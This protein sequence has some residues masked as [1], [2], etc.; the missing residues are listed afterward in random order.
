MKNETLLDE[1]ITKELE[2]LGKMSMDSEG[3]TKGVEG[4]AKLLDKRIELERIKIESEDRQKEID[5]KQAQMEEDRKDRLIK[6]IIAA[7]SVGAPIGVI[8]WGTIKS[9]EFEEKGTVTTIMGRGFIGNIIKLLPR[10]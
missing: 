7:V 10:L 5:L 4:I 2:E 3:Y 9:F 8:V 1:R 6:N